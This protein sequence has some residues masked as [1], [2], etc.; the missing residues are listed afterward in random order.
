MW[1]GCKWLCWL[2]L[3]VTG[4]SGG[5]GGDEGGG[6]IGRNVVVVLAREVVVISE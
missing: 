5:V 2:A 4:V 3:V 6:D 1:C